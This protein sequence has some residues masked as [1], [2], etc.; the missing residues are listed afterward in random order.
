MPSQAPPTF[1]D[2]ANVTSSSPRQPLSAAARSRASTRAVATVQRHRQE[3]RAESLAQIQAQIA[4][5]TLVVR[6]MTTAE[7]SSASGAAR[8]TRALPPD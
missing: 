4:D 3:R 6:Q 5:G 1:A 2:Q 7:R 8:L